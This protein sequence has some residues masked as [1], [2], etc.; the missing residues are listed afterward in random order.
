MVKY[1]SGGHVV[2]SVIS[3]LPSVGTDV[4]CM[5]LFGIIY[6][7]IQN[8]WYQ[9]Y[10]TV[11]AD[12]LKL[13]VISTFEQFDTDS[14]GLISR[15]ELKAVLQR[16]GMARP[17]DRLAKSDRRNTCTQPPGF[18]WKRHAFRLMFPARTQWTRL[19]PNFTAQQLDELMTSID[20]DVSGILAA[21]V[22][23]LY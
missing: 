2:H 12:A 23:L 9:I 13:Q 15:E 19:D 17:Y 18:V 4:Q 10:S 21:W 14:N 6:Q 8:R 7:N 5:A 11:S 20:F 22:M 1:Q 16:R 3:S